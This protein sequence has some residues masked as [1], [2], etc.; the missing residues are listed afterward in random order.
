[1]NH[2]AITILGGGIAGL[3]TSIALKKIGINTVIFE[4]SA[5]IAAVGAGLGVGVN[6]IKALRTLGLDEEIIQQGKS[7]NTFS[8]RDQKGK[9]VS[10]T[11]FGENN[12]AIHRANLYN[13]LLSKIDSQSIHLGK[14]VKIIENLSTGV[15]LLFEDGTVHH[16]N[17]LIVADGVNSVARQMLLSNAKPRYAGYTCWRAVIDSDSIQNLEPTETWGK[18]G[19]FGMVPLAENKIYWFACINALQNDPK[20]KKYAISDLVKHFADYHS[21]IPEIL[22]RTK[23]EDLIHNDIV[24]LAPLRQFAH[25]RIVLIGD[26]AHA[27]TPNMGQGACQAIEDAVVLGKSL[28]EESTV[29][30]AFK[31]FE[32]Q[33]LKRTK[34]IIETSNR[35]GKVAQLENPFIIRIRNL[36][37][38][39]IPDSIKNKQFNKINDITFN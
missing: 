24:D 4:A 38:R 20:F 33:R 21:P 14:R 35:I 17:Y 23:N 16:T 12:L 28:T 13:V 7:L 27:T 5:K 11:I 37:M 31:K 6:A 39:L 9:V 8:I 26:A 32:T 22:L 3:T 36:F 25:G 29:E 15:R 19:R 18:N 1:M 34:W 10:K 30:L 2:N